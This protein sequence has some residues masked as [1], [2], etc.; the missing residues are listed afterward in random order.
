MRKA[1]SY[2]VS[3]AAVSCVV[4]PRY[5]PNSINYLPA[6]QVRLNDQVKGK[7]LFL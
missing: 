3:F 7:L 1:Y 5:S 2:L 6:F 4:T